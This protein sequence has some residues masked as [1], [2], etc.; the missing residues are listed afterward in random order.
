MADTSYQSKYTGDQVQ[1]TL[2]DILN[3][4]KTENSGKFIAVN[5]AGKFVAQQAVTVTGTATSGQVVVSNG[6]NV[7][8]TTGYT[9]A[10][11]VPSGA[12]FTD[13]TYSDATTSAHGLMT[14]ADKTKLNGIATGAEVNQNAFSNVVV[15]STTIAADSKT[16]S[17]TLVAGSNIT[18][19]PDATN[20]KVT[21][22]A[23]NTTYSDATT[24]AHGLMSTS[25]KSKLDGIATGATKVTTDTVSG[26]GYTKNTG[27]VTVTG[28]ATSGQVVVSNGGNVIK[29]TGYTIAK[30]VPSDAVFT[31]TKN[32]AGSTDTSSKIFL[33]GATSQAANPQT[34]SDNQIYATNGQLDA[35]K[36]RIGEHCTLQYNATTQ[37]LDFVFA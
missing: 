16:D 34:Y 23:T 28:T 37:A 21:I 29:T 6:G 5:S 33:V 14:A 1:G 30:S 9:I 2:E 20:D 10:T 22:A 15:G 25:D 32:T 11:S 26:W 31:D 24:S 3:V 18:L 7:I 8:K 19:T 35:N 27:T 36:V 4:E 12:K 17:L 13:T